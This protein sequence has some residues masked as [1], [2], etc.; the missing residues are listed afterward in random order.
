VIE[1]FYPPPVQSRSFILQDARDRDLVTARRA[2]LL[3][4]IWRERYL[5]REGLLWRVEALLGRGC[6]GASAWEDVFYRDIR[7]VKGAL[8]AAGYELRYSRRPE[9]PGYYLKGEPPLCPEIATALRSCAADIDPEQIRIFRNM[10]VAE[11][12]QPGFSVSEA[13]RQAARQH[14]VRGKGWNVRSEGN[15][16]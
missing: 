8:K 3:E 11:R 12:F 5:T 1:N 6:F 15:S 7:V 14:Q 16:G 4:Y 9:Q 2:L 13:A 10:S